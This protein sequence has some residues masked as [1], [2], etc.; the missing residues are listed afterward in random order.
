MPRTK[1]EPSEL[2]LRVLGVLWRLGP[3]TVREVL[4]ALGDD[5]QRGYTTV[6]STVQSLQRKKLV[7]AKRPRGERAYRYAA[8][9]SR[10]SIVGPLLGGLVDRVFGGDPAAAVAQLLDASSLGEEDIARLR[11]VVAEA[12]RRA[13]DPSDANREGD[14]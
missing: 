12:E 3:S 9:K 5:K 14:R 2:E 7:T 6:L 11:Q 4:D 1:Q 8:R 13:A 10:E